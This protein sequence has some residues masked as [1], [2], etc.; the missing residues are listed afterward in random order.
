[1]EVLLDD[2]WFILNLGL[3]SSPSESAGRVMTGKACNGGCFESLRLNTR[4]DLGV[5]HFI[6]E[7]ITRQ[8]S[9]QCRK[10]SYKIEWSSGR[11]VRSRVFLKTALGLCDKG[12]A[13][14]FLVAA[15][16]PVD[17]GG[18]PYALYPTQLG[19]ILAGFELYPKVK[20]GIDAIF[21]WYRLWV[22][23][24]K[25]LR[26]E[27]DTVQAVVDSTLYVSF[28]LYV[29]AALALFYAGT[30]S[31][32]EGAWYSGTALPHLAWLYVPRPLVM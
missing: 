26:E 16:W 27:I 20:Y 19:N 18:D 22:S 1:M 32:M 15:E 13:A 11:R 30:E 28:T 2:Y 24:D 21:Y 5:N 12:V 9:L 8:F 17:E 23:L 3:S 7:V 29:S 10:Y 14:R 4:E 25:D 31:L 6:L